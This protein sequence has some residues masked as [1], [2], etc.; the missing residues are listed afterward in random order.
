MNNLD[1][2]NSDELFEVLVSLLPLD[3]VN[4]NTTNTNGVILRGDSNDDSNNIDNGNSSRDMDEYEELQKEMTMLRLRADNAERDSDRLRGEMDILLNKNTE[5]TKE[6]LSYELMLKESEAKYQELIQS[7]EKRDYDQSSNKDYIEMMDASI[8]LSELKGKVEAKEKSLIQLREENERIKDEHKVQM[9][10]MNKELN[11]LKE[12]KVKYEMLQM[13]TKKFPIEEMYLIKQ[14]LLSSE[15]ALKEKEEEVNKLKSND[16]RMLLL[17]KIEELNLNLTLTKDQNSSLQFN[18]DKYKSLLNSKE[19]ELN[20]N[21]N[22]VNRNDNHNSGITLGIIEEDE[23]R[24]VK[25]KELETKYEALQHENSTLH[26]TVNEQQSMIDKLSKKVDKLTK[27]KSEN[28]TY[29]TKL[30]DLLDKV[31]RTNCEN[32]ELKNQL[33]DNQFKIK[34]L[35]NKNETLINENT[36]YKETTQKNQLYIDEL[37][38]KTKDNSNDSQLLQKLKAYTEKENAELKIQIQTKED[39][40]KEQNDKIKKTDLELQELNSKLQFIPNE[41]TKR[42]VE[43]E[44]YKNQLEQKEMIYN[45]ELRVITKLFYS[46]SGKYVDI[47]HNNQNISNKNINNNTLSSNKKK[48]TGYIERSSNKRTLN[49]KE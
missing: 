46:L 3:E 42:E 15:R 23:I 14:K 9:L 37:Q 35:E 10:N 43:I 45:E 1:K 18:I 48:S 25:L 38:K 20:N 26:V 29:L 13:Q 33:N 24:K 2:T 21:N 8:K 31:E 19:E 28:Q 17:N 39:I 49:S 34:E 6:V 27:Y 22:N 44:F 41:L 12:I 47:K 16:D 11:A 32:V 4:A 30:T 5:L 7:I 36:Q 40:I